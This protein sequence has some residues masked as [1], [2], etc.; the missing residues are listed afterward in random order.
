MSDSDKGLGP[1]ESLRGKQ[2][3]TV[4]KAYKNLQTQELQL[5]VEEATMYL[6]IALGHEEIEFSKYEQ[7]CSDL[8]KARGKSKY[9]LLQ[10]CNNNV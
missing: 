10:K 7:I 2:R 3:E 9:I 6:E 5:G 4:N 1:D 8:E